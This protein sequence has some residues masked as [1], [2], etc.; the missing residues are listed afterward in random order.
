MYSS[1]EKA[2]DSL[3]TRSDSLEGLRPTLSID[4]RVTMMMTGKVASPNILSPELP[5]NRKP[6]RLSVCYDNIHAQQRLVVERVN[7]AASVR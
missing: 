3:F 1:L 7:G 6:G 5:Q 4:G 2:H